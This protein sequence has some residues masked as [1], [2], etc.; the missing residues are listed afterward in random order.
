LTFRSRFGPL[1]VASHERHDARLRAPSTLHA[2][3]SAHRIF[4]P[5]SVFDDCGETILNVV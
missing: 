5:A 2:M 4:I 3:A 1:F